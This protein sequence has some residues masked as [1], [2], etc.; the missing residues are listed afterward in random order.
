MYRHC[1]HH[2]VSLLSAVRPDKLAVPHEMSLHRGQKILFG[3]AFTKPQK[4][5]QRIYPEVI[6]M[7]AVAS[8]RMRTPVP[9]AAETVLSLDGPRDFRN[10]APA[11]QALRQ[12]RSCLLRGDVRDEPVHEGFGARRVRILAEECERSQ[13]PVDR[14]S[15][16]PTAEIGGSDGPRNAAN[17]DK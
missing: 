7:D 3:E 12:P 10:A 14:G 16:K 4:G 1:Q 11:G 17:P 5:I 6:V 9:D 15:N 2:E 8:R 13:P